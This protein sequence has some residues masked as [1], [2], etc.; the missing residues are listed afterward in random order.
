MRFTI[1]ETGDE[2]AAVQRPI[3]II[4]S[5]AEKELPDAS[6]A[7]ACSIS[8]TSPDRELMARIVAVHHPG[9]DDA[10]LGQ[11]LDVFYGVR[12][13]PNLRKRPSTSELVDWI[14]GPA[15]QGVQEVAL[16]EDMPF[17]GTLLKKEQ[18]LQAFADQVSG[19]SR[20]RF[21]R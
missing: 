15:G 8:S 6:C 5:N 20:P 9:L 17:V 11:A 14:A 3:V 7:G 12:D 21:G 10:L 13:P 1:A 18:D 16:R 2:V 19:R 4:T